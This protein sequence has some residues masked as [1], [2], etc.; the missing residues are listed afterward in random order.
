L[1]GYSISDSGVIGGSYPNGSVQNFAAFQMVSLAEI[2][3]T[4]HKGGKVSAW[5][6]IFVAK[7]LL[8][9]GPHKDSELML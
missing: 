7:W 8:K 6:G 3:V 5:A 2:G 1:N 4:I 9:E